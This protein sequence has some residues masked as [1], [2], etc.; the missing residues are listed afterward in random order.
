MMIAVEEWRLD[1]L[2]EHAELLGALWNRRLR[3]ERSAVHDLV[4]LRRLDRRIEANADALVLAGGHAAKHLETLLAAEEAPAAA[5]A[6]TVVARTDAAPAIAQLA[7][8]LV[9]AAPEVRAGA[10]AALDL[11]A[12]PALRET[13]AKGFAEPEL[14]AGAVA[15]LASH[16]EARAVAA[17]PERFL[18]DPSPVAR[19]LGWRAVRRLGDAIRVDPRFYQYG[20]VDADPAARREA[21]AAGAA[22]RQ[23]WVLE[24]LR[25]VAATPDPQ[26]LE[27]HLLFAILAGPADLPLVRTLGASPAL[28]WDRYRILVLCG[29]AAAVE[30]LLVVMKGADPVEGALAA[31]AFYRITGIDVTGEARTPLVAA[32]SAPDDFTDEIRCCDLARAEKVWSATKADMAGGRWSYGVDAEAA[33]PETLPD[34]VDL[35]ARWAAELRAGFR[36]ARRRLRFTHERLSA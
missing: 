1:I 10:W 4:T 14:G 15:A 27:E 20:L 31:A 35:E 22:T 13:L 32:G 25:Q 7:D 11:S 29:R 28:G 30:D 6:A 18:F 23:P 3:A 19:A 26:R 24:F 2:E 9:A 16:D 12:G 34:A 5:A 33:A 17:Q 21:L 36:D 8:A